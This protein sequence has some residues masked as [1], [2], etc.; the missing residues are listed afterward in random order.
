MVI[1]VINWGNSFSVFCLI[2]PRNPLTISMRRIMNKPVSH[3]KFDKKKK[4]QINIDKMPVTP[5]M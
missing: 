5:K 1:P 3:K 4:A 2:S